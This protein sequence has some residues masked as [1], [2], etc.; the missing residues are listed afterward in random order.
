MNVLRQVGPRLR[1]EHCGVNKQRQVG[2]RLRREHCGVTGRGR[3]VS[4]QKKKSEEPSVSHYLW[5]GILGGGHEVWCVLYRKTPH[6]QV[7]V[8]SK[9]F[10][11]VD[12]LIFQKTK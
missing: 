12:Y 6:K 7:L 4:E 8:H 5:D 10:P 2:P 3:W 9:C 1:R 11:N